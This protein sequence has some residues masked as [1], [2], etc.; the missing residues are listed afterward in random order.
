MTTRKPRSIVIFLLDGDPE[1]IRTAHI[2]LSTVRA[3]AFGIN[4][5]ARAATE[6]PETCRPGVYLRLGENDDGKKTAY[7]G[8]SE[9]VNQRLKYWAATEPDT[10]TDAIA[11]VVKDDGVTTAHAQF[12]EA[13]LI[14]A[15]KANPAWAVDDNKQT[16]SSDNKHLP[17]PDKYTMEA[18]IE[19]VKTLSGALG[20]DLFK[21]QGTKS[22]QSPPP[23][24]KATTAG[25]DTEFRMASANYDATAIVSATTGHMW[26]QPKSRIKSEPTAAMPKGVRELR[27]TLLADGVLKH[28]ADTVTFTKAWEFSSPSAA[29]CMVTGT[30]TAGTK[31][32][33]TASTPPQTYAEWLA[34]ESN[35]TNG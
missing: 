9:D 16:P 3:V 22:E 2:P 34:G 4:Q 33:K 11:F 27:K 21:T 10:W 24:D 12:I 1:G 6:F 7:V 25:P 30:A 19:Q 13:E 23:E 20:C 35:D 18:F 26:I 15:A 32:W 17:R 14:Q 29:A 28:E 5:I 8:Q 31:S